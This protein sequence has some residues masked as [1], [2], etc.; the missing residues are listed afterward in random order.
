MSEKGLLNYRIVG[1]GYPVVFL[2]GFLESNTMWDDLTPQLSEKYKCIFI[3]LPGHGE[4]PCLD[5]ETP[6]IDI[7]A[8]KVLS[9]VDS[10]ISNPFSIV[11]HSL[12]GYVALKVITL[13]KTFDEKLIL[14]NSHPWVDSTTKRE[15]RDRVIAVVEKNKALFIQTA[16]P[17]LYRAPIH[18]KNKISSMI[19]E[20]MGMKDSAILD[21]LKAMRDRPECK[22]PMEN[23][24][25]NCLVIQGKYDHLIDAS[26]MEDLTDAQDNQLKVIQDAGHMAHHENP[27]EV[28]EGII[29]FI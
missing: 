15:E 4:S 27:K 23:L 5:V 9:T 22:R 25:S 7:M 16:I 1:D 24:K 10:L 3:E 19:E 29:G 26:K 18:H 8:D 13:L 20:A 21:S 6:S 12:G 28:V 11:G 2:H 17:N 14:L